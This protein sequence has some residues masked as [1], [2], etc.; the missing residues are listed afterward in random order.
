[1]PVGFK[2]NVGLSRVSA[3]TD[4]THA[5]FTQSVK[6]SMAAIISEYKRWA[7]HMDEQAADVLYDALKPTFELSQELV[8]VATG[9]LKESGYLEKRHSQGQASVEI[10]YARGGN[11]DYAVIVHE[12]P[13]MPHKPPTQNKFLQQPLEQDFENVRARVIQGMKDISGV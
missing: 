9:V 5:N 12:D 10:G 13:D 3:K 1:M 8:P 7:Q 6:S 11:P 4:S 2:G